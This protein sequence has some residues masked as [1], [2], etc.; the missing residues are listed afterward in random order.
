MNRERRHE[1]GSGRDGVSGMGLGGCERR[2]TTRNMFDVLVGSLDE[3]S[4]QV[5]EEEKVKK[6]QAR[7]VAAKKQRQ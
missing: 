4:S 7:K 1:V 2:R 3:I 6:A 5:L